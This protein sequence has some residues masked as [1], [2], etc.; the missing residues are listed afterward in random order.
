[1]KRGLFMAAFVIGLGAMAQAQELRW[2]AL[3]DVIGVEADDVLNIRAE[4]SG[5]AP[6]IGT[7]LPDAVGVEVVGVN[8]S[9]A[10]GRVNTEEQ[11]GWVSLRFLSRRAGQDY[12][13]P[14]NPKSCFGTEPFWFVDLEIGTDSFAWLSP[15]AEQTGAVIKRLTSHNQRDIQ[16]MI[17]RFNAPAE[18]EPLAWNDG[19]MVMRPAACS[20]GMSDR[21]YGIHADLVVQRSDGSRLLSGCCTL[22]N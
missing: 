3:H 12:G 10:W 17:L 6:V 11:S 5:S 9:G 2:P 22:A 13:D 1:M 14:L 19:V 8:K 16:S 4:P 21:S 15:E 7:L 18:A 20:D